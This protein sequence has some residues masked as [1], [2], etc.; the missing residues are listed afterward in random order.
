MN[1]W[2][3][4]LSKKRISKISTIHKNL[5]LFNLWKTTFINCKSK[6]TKQILSNNIKQ[7]KKQ[8]QNRLEIR[9]KY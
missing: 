3:N 4:F 7:K 8:I 2:A 6:K 5:V 9:K 1:K